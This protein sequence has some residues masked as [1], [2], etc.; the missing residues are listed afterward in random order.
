MLY[1]TSSKDSL[2]KY[3]RAFSVKKSRPGSPIFIQRHSTNVTITQGFIPSSSS[4]YRRTFGAVKSVEQ[5]HSTKPLKGP[6]GR[7]LPREKSVS[8]C[9]RRSLLYCTCWIRNQGG[10][11]FFHSS[12]GKPG[13]VSRARAT[14]PEKTSPPCL[15]LF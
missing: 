7:L 14:S 15:Q 6:K 13:P 3:Y 8:T 9:C 2:K 10:S 12:M 5:I 1:G 11:G 4:P